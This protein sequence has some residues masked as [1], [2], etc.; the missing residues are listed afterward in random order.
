MIRPLMLDDFGPVRSYDRA[1]EMLADASHALPEEDRLSAFEK[2]YKSGWD[3]CLTAESEARAHISADL[4]RN[5]QEMAFTYAEARR[6]VLLA[7][8]PLFN[9]ITDSLLPTVAAAAIGP[10][11][12]AE[13]GAIAEHATSN[14]AVELR[15]APAACAALEK[16]TGADD[17]L[18]I[19]IRP[20]PAFAEG[21]ISVRFGGEEREIDLCAAAASM[22][23]VIRTVTQEMSLIA[24]TAEVA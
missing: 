12:T 24:P 19:S 5:L 10:V 18:T 3:D 15:A 4:A 1:D 2:G 6:D 17:R 7:L 13:L 8:T 16:I 20:E 9:Q 21:Q 23:E 14:L 22:A 11:L